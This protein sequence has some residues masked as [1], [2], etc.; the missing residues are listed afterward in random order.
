MM[1]RTI[2]SSASRIGWHRGRMTTATVIGSVVVR[3]AIAVARI[4]GDGR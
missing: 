2:I 3:A 1:S 4:S